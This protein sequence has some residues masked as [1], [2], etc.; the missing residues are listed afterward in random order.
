MV[1]GGAAKVAGKVAGRAVGVGDFVD[2]ASIMA[3]GVAG[4]GNAFDAMGQR[5][6]QDILARLDKPG[7][8]AGGDWLA[9]LGPRG[10][11]QSF[12]AGSY[13]N[14][15][16]TNYK[17]A[18]ERKW[19]AA[20]FEN[21][22]RWAAEAAAKLAPPAAAPTVP[23]LPSAVPLVASEPSKRGWQPTGPATAAHYRELLAKQQRMAPG[24]GP[25]RAAVEGEMK[26]VWSQLHAP[27]PAGGSRSA[28]ASGG[29]SQR[30]LPALRDSSRPWG[31]GPAGGAKTPGAAALDTARVQAEL[32]AVAAAAGAAA[33]GLSGLATACAAALA[34][35]GGGGGRPR[36]G[37][38]A[39]HALGE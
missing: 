10:L 16:P 8:H 9:G 6:E 7:A 1:A 13:V 21:Q 28:G 20:K 33:S 15:Q 3:G 12:F 30:T 2:T 17:I 37:L 18:D 11:I 25:A 5:G 22:Q 39:G 4:G 27:A 31:G 24:Q 38:S 23:P 19:R 36:L 14:R 29:F 32:N 26:D 35:L 34:Q